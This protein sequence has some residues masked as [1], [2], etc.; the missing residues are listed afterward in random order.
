MNEMV[1]LG[2]MS[3]SSL[4]GLD[5]SCCTYRKEGEKWGFQFIAGETFKFPDGI[6]RELLRVRSL[7]GLQLT[8]LD[9]VLGK[10]IGKS[11]KAFIDSKNLKP[12]LIGSHGHTVFHDVSKGLTLQIG[13]GYEISLETGV[14]VYSDF[15]MKD[16]LLGGQGAPLVPIGDYHLFE[17]YDACLNLGGI[18]NISIKRDNTI[19][20]YDVAPCNQVLNK[21][22]EPL[23]VEFDDAGKLART[24][25][26]SQSWIEELSS[27][28][29]YDLP[30]PKSIS[31]EWVAKEVISSIPTMDL[32][33]ALHT[34]N[35]FIASTI[36][37]DLN[38]F[39]IDNVLIT[40]GG[41]YNKFL[42]E[43][44]K[45]MVPSMDLDVPDPYLIDFKEAIVIGLMGIL[46]HRG[47]INVLSSVTGASR[48]SC[49]GALYLP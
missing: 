14:P 8:E 3:G 18:A 12:E 17:H 37:H 25:K 22:V 32:V 41:A 45:E 10:W 29:F 40:G 16:I 23:N 24:G 47:E 39:G 7:S 6:M 11:C 38:K 31:N 28:K 48:D 34:F 42:I 2:V 20:A 1:A 15:R 26:V 21:I 36:T 5:V 30:F 43:L 27:N 33:D 49:S 35:H 46:R 44:M 9:K 19:Y 13:N 4:D